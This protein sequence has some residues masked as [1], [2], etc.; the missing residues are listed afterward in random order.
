MSPA[1][2]KNKFWTSFR[3]LGGTIERYARSKYLLK[4]SC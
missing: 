3:E 1:V 4:N 2:M